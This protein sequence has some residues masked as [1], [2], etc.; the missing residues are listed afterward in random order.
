MIQISWAGYSQKDREIVAKRILAKQDSDQI[1]YITEGKPFYRSKEERRENLKADKSTWFRALG[2]TTTLR[3]PM[4][5]NSGLAKRLREVV[6]KHQGPKGTSVKVVEQP[7]LPVMASLAKGDPFPKDQCT[8]GSC[9]LAGP[10]RGQCSRESVLYVATC[11]ICYDKQLEE[12]V[13]P[14]DVVERMYIGET[15]RT[16]RVRSSQ[17]QRDY[18]RCSSN[19]NLEPGTSF[20]WD[21]YSETHGGST[22]PTLVDPKAHFSFRMISCFRDPM[23]RQLSEASRIQSGLNRG[24]FLNKEDKWEPIISLNRKNEFFR[25]RK[26]FD[27]NQD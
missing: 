20:M 26:R 4:T 6:A 12:G 11:N 13:D 1:S 16:I 21:H 19:R 8:R 17:H 10:C 14:E 7:G 9:P 2:A 5:R 25:A 3:I 22:T 24:K 18:L 27:H 23:S 15:S